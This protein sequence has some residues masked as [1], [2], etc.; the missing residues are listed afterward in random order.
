MCEYCGCQ[1]LSSIA[2][3]TAEHDEVV[4][5]IGS[6]RRAVETVLAEAGPDVTGQVGPMPDEAWLGRLAG[7]LHLLR[8]HILAEQDGAFPAAL[9]ALDPEDWDRVDEVRARVGS[10]VPIAAPAG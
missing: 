6:A 3:L 1:A 8:E 5:A 2:Q 9:G 7:V 4:N 10:E